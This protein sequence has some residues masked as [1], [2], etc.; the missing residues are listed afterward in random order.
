MRGAMRL[1]FQPGRLLLPCRTSK[2]SRMVSRQLRLTAVVLIVL[3]VVGAVWWMQRGAK[4]QSEV[5]LLLWAGYDEPSLIKPF[6]DKYGV[7]VNYK[8][9]VGGDAM[10][11]LL[12]QSKG[13]YDAVIVDP[14]YIEKLHKIGR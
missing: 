3:A 11:A 7:K 6:E 5:N 12:T 10:F 9:F 8:T 2:R 1:S 4:Q 14:E 13:V